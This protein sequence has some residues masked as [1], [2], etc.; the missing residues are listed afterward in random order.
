MGY[1]R[2]KEDLQLVV[3]FGN[4]VQ[5]FLLERRNLLHESVFGEIQ[6]AGPPS[7]RLQHSRTFIAQNVQVIDEIVD[8]LKVAYVFVMRGPAGATHHNRS[9]S[10]FRA[11]LMDDEFTLRLL[12]PQ[13]VI[14]TLNALLAAC[15]RDLKKERRNLLNPF[16]WLFQGL[17]L[18]LRLPFVLLEAAGFHPD[19][20]EEQ[21]AG[22]L[23]KLIELAILIGLAYWVGVTKTDVKS[24]VIKRLG[25]DTE[26]KKAESSVDKPAPKSESLIKSGSGTTKSGH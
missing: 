3:Q 7:E 13:S 16:H 11:I 5:S 8:R 25:G 19:K 15:Q 22:K 12:E 4:N 1:W 21:F 24:I 20:I 17:R 9:I 6:P 2:A 18:I 23:F 10:I 14:D 26:Q